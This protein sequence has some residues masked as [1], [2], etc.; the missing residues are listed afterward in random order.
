MPP[1]EHDGLPLHH[2]LEAQSR[3]VHD[4]LSHAHRLAEINHAL[5]HR[6]WSDEGWIAQV[7]VA[8]IRDQTVVL[9]SASAAALVPLRYRSQELLAWLNQRFGL[10]CT[11]LETKVRPGSPGRKGGV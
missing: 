8:N 1:T 5:Q 6:Q 2:W 10:Q 11:Q 7:R 4:L 3:S 9:F